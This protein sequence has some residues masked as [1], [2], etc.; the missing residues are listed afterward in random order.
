[1]IKLRCEDFDELIYLFRDGEVDQSKKE[2]VQKHLSTCNRCKRKL[3]LLESIEKKAKEIKVKEPSQEYWDTFSNRVRERLVARTEKSFSFKLKKV[4]ENIFTFSP[5]KVKIAA[6][7]ISVI[8]VFIVGKLYMDYRGRE[9][10]PSKTTFEETKK[11]IPFSQ[12]GSTSPSEVKEKAEPKELAIPQGE[13]IE[14]K[15]M[16]LPPKE[17]TKPMEALT[18]EAE[19]KGEKTP[20]Q[21]ELQK[22]IVP[23]E[24]KAQKEEKLTLPTKELE[25]APAS[26]ITSKE[27]SSIDVL[28]SKDVTPSVRTPSTGAGAKEKGETLNMVIQPEHKVTDVEGVTSK[29]TTKTEEGKTLSVALERAI[30]TPG[31]S[32]YYLLEG[33]KVLQMRVEDTLL[34]EHTLIRII[35]RWNRYIEKNPKDS[36]TNEGYLQVAIGYYL[37]SKLTLDQSV[38]SKGIKLLE[39]YE[40]QSTDPKIKEGLNKRLKELKALKRK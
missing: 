6:G 29:E 25:K 1:V 38:I 27:E 9:I 20:T 12:K 5:L 28:E 18:S 17:E 36:L 34:Q 15:G 2:E 21:V 32:N 26:R 16:I 13:K 10:M 40:K 19:G 8:F 7:V 39:K 11:L 31:A 30:E 14:K 33:D 37:L 35:H 24:E 23:P 4:F 3:A 22:M